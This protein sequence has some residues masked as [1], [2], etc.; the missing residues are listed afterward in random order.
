MSGPDQ[1]QAPSTRPDPL[2]DDLLVHFSDR[3]QA[4]AAAALEKATQLPNRDVSYARFLLAMAFWRL[5][6]KDR[7]RRWYDLAAA[8]V[9]LHEVR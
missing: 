7:A 6:E 4:G 8:Q 9:D 5:G 1:P 3:L 2:L